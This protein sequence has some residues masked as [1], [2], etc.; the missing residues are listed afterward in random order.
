MRE[1]LTFCAAV[2]ERFQALRILLIYHVNKCGIDPPP[3]F[4]RVKTADDEV[5][6]H[7]VCLILVLDLPKVAG[8]DSL[9]YRLRLLGHYRLTG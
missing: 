9:Q 1:E 2:Y 8:E 4:N 6:L 5:E 7:V 3:C